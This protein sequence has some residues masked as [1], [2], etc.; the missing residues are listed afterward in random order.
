MASPSTHSNDHDDNEE[1]GSTDEGAKGRVA[2][3]SDDHGSELFI[4][5][6]Q[7]STSQSSPILLQQTGQSLP[8]G[9]GKAVNDPGMNSP[10]VEESLQQR[11]KEKEEERLHLVRQQQ[12][13][14]GG[15]GGRE[16]RQGDEGNIIGQERMATSTMGS[17]SLPESHISTLHSQ[18]MDPDQKRHQQSVQ[19]DDDNCDN[20]DI[21]DSCHGPRSSGFHFLRRPSLHFPKIPRFG[22][23]KVKTTPV[24]PIGRG[25]DSPH[26]KGA[27]VCTQNAPPGPSTNQ[28]SLRSR[29]SWTGGNVFTPTNDSSATG[30]DGG[31]EEEQRRRRKGRGAK[32][33]QGLA[34]SNTAPAVPSSDF[35][36]SQRLID[37]IVNPL[38]ERTMDSDAG[39][40]S[41]AFDSEEERDADELLRYL[42][43]DRPIQQKEHQLQQFQQQQQQHGARSFPH[44]SHRHTRSMT[45]VGHDGR[46]PQHSAISATFHGDGSTAA[47]MHG[48][49]KKRR[50]LH[51]QSLSHEPGHDS[52]GEI[53]NSSGSSSDDNGASPSAIATASSMPAHMHGQRH[54]SKARDDDTSPSFSR[55]RKRT[56]Q[57]RAKKFRKH[58]TIAV[59][60]SV[61]HTSRIS[62]PPPLMH[63]ASSAFVSAATHDV[64]IHTYTPGSAL[65]SMPAAAATTV[66]PAALLRHS[67]DTTDHHAFVGD[68]SAPYGMNRKRTIRIEELAKSASPTPPNY[69]TMTSTTTTTS[70]DTTTGIDGHHRRTAAGDMEERGEDDEPEEGAPHPAHTYYRTMTTD[71]FEQHLKLIDLVEEPPSD[72]DG[73]GADA[74]VQRFK[75]WL[76]SPHNYRIL[77][78]CAG[79]LMP[80]NVLLNIIS[81]GNGWLI[82]NNA[83]V[84]EAT[85][86][87]TKSVGY[88]ISAAVSL[89]LICVSAI[90]FV[91]RC[92]EFNVQ[93]TT[94][95][96]VL[97]NLTAS[98]ISLVSAIVF[99]LVIRPKSRDT[100]HYSGEYYS[101]YAGCVVSL[102]DA[103]LL[104]IDAW[105]TPGFRFR[106]SGMSPKQRILQL[107]IIIIIIWLGIGGVVYSSLEDWDI[108]ESLFFCVVTFATI[109]F[110]N[111]TVKTTKNRI[112]TIFYGGVGILFFGLLLL[113][114]RNVVIQ[115][116]TTKYH[117]KRRDFERKRL[118]WLKNIKIQQLRNRLSARPLPFWRKAAFDMFAKILHTSPRDAEYLGNVSRF[119]NSQA[120]VHQQQD[121]P[122]S[123]SK[124]SEALE[125]ES[126]RSSPKLIGMHSSSP[127]T[128]SRSSSRKSSSRSKS[129][130]SGSDNDNDNNL[131]SSDTPDPNK[132]FTDP[133][134]EASKNNLDNTSAAVRDNIQPP[135]AAT[136]SGTGD[137][138]RSLRVEH[139]QQPTRSETM[140]LGMSP[141]RI[142]KSRSIDMPVKRSS[143]A[144]SS[145]S[146]FLASGRESQESI[147]A[148]NNNQSGKMKELSAVADY[149]KPVNPNDNGYGKNVAPG[150]NSMDDDTED[151][152]IAN[153]SAVSTG[154][155]QTENISKTS[156]PTTYD[157]KKAADNDVDYEDIYEKRPA[158]EHHVKTSQVHIPNAISFDPAATNNH[159]E[160][161]LIANE[162]AQHYQYRRRSSDF[163][164]SSLY[165][166]PYGRRYSQLSESRYGDNDNIGPKDQQAPH[167]D[168]HQHH[169]QTPKS[170]SSKGVNNSGGSRTKLHT[171]Y[172]KSGNS[173]RNQGKQ[174]QKSAQT[175]HRRIGTKARHCLFA[176]ALNIIFWMVCSGIYAGI[177]HAQWNFFDA[178]WF[179]FVAFTTIGYGDVVPKTTIGMIVFIVMTFLAVALETYLVV[180]AVTY[181]DGLLR[182]GVR[183]TRVRRR[184][185]KR[186]KTIISEELRRVATEQGVAIG[187]NVY[188]NIQDIGGRARGD[189][190]AADGDEVGAGPQPIRGRASLFDSDFDDEFYRSMSQRY[191]IKPLSPSRKL[192]KLGKK[193]KDR[194]T[195]RGATKRRGG[196]SSGSDDNYGRGSVSRSSSNSDINDSDIVP[197][198]RF[199]N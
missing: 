114:T 65:S 153:M 50:N 178:M 105:T 193:L 58:P 173:Q 86:Y 21:K 120:S 97:S 73:G 129:Y 2:G 198:W 98:I 55:R 71:P 166:R 112:F 76:K 156:S 192:K 174:H 30:G 131:H 108:V 74:R 56:K 12:D 184:I 89:I 141:R 150:G 179:C 7:S 161:S 96:S 67:G 78:S 88:T 190:E 154:H 20:N 102:F 195:R 36:Y 158:G 186:R 29:F 199:A 5:Q 168:H 62:V 182:A 125:D 126:Q 48:W 92:L 143:K 133:W 13:Q 27:N 122:L 69:A 115:I 130:D 16:R 66:E 70:S 83:P 146:T 155:T 183:S 51:D 134:A 45:H 80:I 63:P 79:Y 100:A 119:G 151:V 37:S 136:A 164:E 111:Q 33:P 104:I 191:P 72:G 17:A 116:V 189:G 140:T 121:E 34:G 46:D 187:G 6:Q 85:S 181:F 180:S 3:S 176:L 9:I 53:G 14:P 15:E 142:T 32:S 47:A 1:E 57:K 127:S 167:H 135:V 185:V 132:V 49:Y 194:V 93:Y 10:Q 172:N 54:P 35:P 91:L 52:D 59:C 26:S 103:S 152:K 95:V 107:N 40:V 177:E 44:L 23:P 84:E 160:T 165:P 61:M 171:G 101:T 28:K 11:Q 18:V 38:I 42:L 148:Y 25:A 197:P 41:E 39:S 138:N 175:K 75:R 87:L 137:N 64:G 188:P 94:T 124:S 82:E 145:M 24:Q 110:G 109:G 31:R 99:A 118:A 144:M 60:P 113:N 128:N 139:V 106:G 43:S 19:G 77:V 68:S 81:L 159:D 90:S 4:E 8:G 162:L 149:D 117:R 163:S 147:E 157:Q 123:P 196:S 22:L 169:A 170:Q